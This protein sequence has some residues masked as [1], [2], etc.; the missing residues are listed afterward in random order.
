M[1]PSTLK[2]IAWCFGLGLAVLVIWRSPVPYQGFAFFPPDMYSVSLKGLYI[3]VLFYL[4][5][6]YFLIALMGYALARPFF[7]GGPV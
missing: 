5:V 3:P 1:M 7:E 2:K 6:N 4:I